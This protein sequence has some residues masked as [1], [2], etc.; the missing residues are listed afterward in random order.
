[1]VDYYGLPRTG[2]GAWPGREAGSASALPYPENVK[3]V[4]DEIKRDLCGDMGQRF[5]PSRFIPFVMIHE[6]E[7]LL[8][9][10]CQRFAEAI[11]REE[12]ASAFQDIRD[13]FS[14]PEQIDDSPHTAPSEAN[15]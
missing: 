11:N 1:M 14:N 5:D 10:D 6:F 8:F 9:S 4:E 15:R 2:P 13:G 12:F 7:A 3:Q